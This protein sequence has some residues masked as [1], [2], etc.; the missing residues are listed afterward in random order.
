MPNP[1]SDSGKQAFQTRVA[2]CIEQNITTMHATADVE[3][4]EHTDVNNLCRRQITAAA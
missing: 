3:R 1:E 4:M 2:S